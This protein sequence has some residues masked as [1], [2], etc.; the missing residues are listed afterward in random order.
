M[1]A[2]YALHPAHHGRTS[3]SNLAPCLDTRRSQHQNPTDNLGTYYTQQLHD[4][5]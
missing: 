2:E 4:S 1:G 5:Q 3:D